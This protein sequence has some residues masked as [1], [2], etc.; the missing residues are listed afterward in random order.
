M[1]TY[2][3][4]KTSFGISNELQP[5]STPLEGSRPIA[6]SENTNDFFLLSLLQ[7]DGGKILLLPYNILNCTLMAFPASP[8]RK[9]SGSLGKYCGKFQS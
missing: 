6:S 1:K 8:G 9:R 3:Q 2:L 5:N 7:F 4:E